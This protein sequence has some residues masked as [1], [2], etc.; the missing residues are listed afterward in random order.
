MGKTRQEIQS[1]LCDL[2]SGALP[3]DAPLGEDS[4][5]ARI[6]EAGLDLQPQLRAAFGL[7]QA[8]KWDHETYQTVRLLLEDEHNPEQAEHGD[9]E[10]SATFTPW[11]PVV[12]SRPL[13]S[14][15][16]YVNGRLVCIDHKKSSMTG[17]VPE[18]KPNASRAQ[19]A[20]GG[21]DPVRTKTGTFKP[22]VAELWYYHP[23]TGMMSRQVF[24]A[25]GAIAAAF[26]R[27]NEV[28]KVWTLEG[29]KD[30]VALVKFRSGNLKGNRHVHLVSAGGYIACPQDVVRWSSQAIGADIKACVG[31]KLGTVKVS[32]IEKMTEQNAQ[33]RDTLG[34][35]A[36]RGKIERGKDL[37]FPTVEPAD[38]DEIV[39]LIRFQSG[40]TRTIS[41]SPLGDDKS[42]ED[43]EILLD[44]HR[45]RAYRLL[46]ENTSSRCDS[47]STISYVV[48]GK[49]E[50]IPTKHTV[51]RGQ[52]LKWAEGEEEK[53]EILATIEAE[54]QDDDGLVLPEMADEYI[55]RKGA[56]LA[57][58][59][60]P[61]PHRAGPAMHAPPTRVDYVNGRHYW[62]NCKNSST[63]G[64]RWVGG[65]SCLEAQLYNMAP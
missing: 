3:P 54:C 25:K 31:E 14:G 21:K 45:K 10:A 29:V 23:E 39:Y 27:A 30:V 6:A 47:P 37:D 64:S 33:F 60:P 53:D 7:H 22:G 65:M 63:P 2:E 11:A 55:K 20:K 46:L 51:G 41:A 28:Q 57:I 40:D 18:A 4:Y 15:W 62:G 34:F 5:F 49:K 42:P 1:W 50:T 35:D 58:I 61:D 17:K 38:P 19:I 59:D 13:P 43:G 44:G 26:R 9:R 48:Y 56:R 32:V 8:G 24:P 36:E 52:A 12:R 16:G